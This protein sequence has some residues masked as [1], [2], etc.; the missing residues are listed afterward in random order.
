[1]ATFDSIWNGL[2]E[3]GQN[4]WKKTGN[5]M[6]VSAKVAQS[7]AKVVVEL[8]ET[9]GEGRLRLCMHLKSGKRKYQTVDRDSLLQDGDTV[10]PKSLV[11][12]TLQKEG[13]DDIYRWDGKAI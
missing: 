12:H 5:P 11:V 7:I 13:E 3:Y 9:Y 10:D 6:K 2:T 4:G 8:D 1:M